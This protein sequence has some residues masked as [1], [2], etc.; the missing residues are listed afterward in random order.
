MTETAQSLL[1]AVFTLQ[2][3]YEQTVDLRPAVS[4]IFSFPRV[5]IA[6]PVDP[7]PIGNRLPS[8]TPNEGR[9][10]GRSP[11]LVSAFIF[12]VCA[13]FLVGTSL[14]MTYGRLTILFAL[15]AIFAVRSLQWKS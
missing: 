11:A 15:A 13:S 7:N 4:S 1:R 2:S 3:P 14:H 10:Y 9:N 6:A 12:G 8:G 5:N